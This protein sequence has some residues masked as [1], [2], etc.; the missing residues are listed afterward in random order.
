MADVITEWRDYFTYLTEFLNECDQHWESADELKVSYFCE[1][2]EFSIR[3]T[4]RLW[5]VVN[6][7][8]N[9]PDIAT[10]VPA[11]EIEDLGSTLERLVGLLKDAWL[12]YF[13]RRQDELSSCDNLFPNLSEN[14]QV[15]LTGTF[16]FIKCVSMY[17]T[18]MHRETRSTQVIGQ[19]GTIRVSLRDAANLLAC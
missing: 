18:F 15:V 4:Q 1:R 11:S 8:G 16:I 12:P 7:A 10:S 17:Y 2:L 13:L 6:Q 9:D 19:S 14:V 3:S 5:D